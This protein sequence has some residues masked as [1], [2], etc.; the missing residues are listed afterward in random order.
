MTN[1]YFER[2]VTRK[3]PV[4]SL[5]LGGGQSIRVQSMTNVHTHDIDACVAQIHRLVQRG[6]EIVRVAVPMP[7]DTAALKE[8]LRQV[9]I[10]VVADVH[11]HFQRALEAIAAGVAKIRLNPGNIQ[12]RSR[13]K[14]SLLLASQRVAIRVG[15]NEGSI[16]ERKDKNMQAS[17][18][19]KNLIDLM[20]E[21]M[22]EYVAILK[23]RIL[24]VWCFPPSVTMPPV[25]SPSTAPWPAAFRI[26]ASWR[27]SRRRYPN[28]LHPFRRRFRRAINGWHWRYHPCFPGRRPRRRSR[29]RWEILASLGLRPRRG[30]ELIACPTCGRTEID[31]LAMVQK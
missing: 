23:K 5:T 8:I 28:R 1:H 2:K 11:F 17:Q 3:V 18:R 25:P 30:P 9:S 26:P 16:V 15:V 6:C 22:V 27:N 13:S 21:K 7:K 12:D 31:L 4:G 14:K 24:T 19:G 10:P 20:T 29:R